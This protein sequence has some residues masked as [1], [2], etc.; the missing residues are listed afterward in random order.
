[1]K[2][3]PDTQWLAD[4]VTQSVCGIIENAGF[5]IFFVGGCVRN[6]VM[7]E[8]IS[9]IDLSTNARPEK[10]MQLA[11]DAGLK[12]IPTGID[13]GTVTVVADGEPYEITTFRRDVETD[14]RRAVVTFSDS[15]EDDAKRRDFTMNA[16]YARPDGTVVDPLGGVLDAT[17]RRVRFIEN[18]SLRIREDYLRTLRYFRFVAW[19][20]AAD[21]GFDTDALDAIASNLDGLERLSAERVGA[22]ILKLLSAPNPAP[23]VAAMRQTG[24]LLQILPGADDRW[25]APLVHMETLL[26]VPPDPIRRLA[27]LGGEDMPRRLRLSKAQANALAVLIDGMSGTQSPAALGYLQGAETALGIVA[28]RSALFETPPALDTATQVQVGV[29]AVFP[30]VSADLTPDFQGK[31][32]GDRLKALKHDWIMSGFTK[33]KDDLLG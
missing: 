16:L 26:D 2:L 32:L 31:A 21:A 9:D 27:V 5:D 14:G 28:L 12:A 22:E 11:R 33:T 3:A 24:V 17:H 15:I 13:H 18:A 29:D 6:A 7:G 8:D 19:Y 20:A 4:P 1:M 25:L 30:I 23:A 10:V